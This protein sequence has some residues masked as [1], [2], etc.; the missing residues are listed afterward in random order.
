MKGFEWWWF[1]AR[2]VNLFLLPLLCFLV[3]AQAHTKGLWTIATSVLSSRWWAWRGNCR[4]TFFSIPCWNLWT[5]IYPNLLKISNCEY[6]LP[7]LVWLLVHDSGKQEIKLSFLEIYSE[8]G[9]PSCEA[10]VKSSNCGL[11]CACT[12]R[13]HLGN[14]QVRGFSKA[15]LREPMILI[16]LI[17]HVVGW[18]LYW[19]AHV[20]PWL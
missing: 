17:S 3:C 15:N 4:F 18:G 14:T 12:P 20:A 9:P 5:F 7:L 8:C 11:S 13:L 6:F 19:P 2:C 16:W 10:C 1:S